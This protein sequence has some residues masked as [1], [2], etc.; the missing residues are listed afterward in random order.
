MRSAQK[1]IDLTTDLK[2]AILVRDFHAMNESL[3]NRE[4]L[5]DAQLEEIHT[6]MAALQS[7]LANSMS[8]LQGVSYGEFR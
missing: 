1:L 3:E 4:Q 7:E 2:Q 8:D 5:L 6:K